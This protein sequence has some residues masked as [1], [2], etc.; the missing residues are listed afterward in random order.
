MEALR[1]GLEIP[2]PGQNVYVRGLSG[3]GRL[4]LVRRVLQEVR[5]GLRPGPDYAYVRRMSQPDRPRLL[6]LPRGRGDDFRERM[7]DVRQFVADELPR[8]LESDG[9][10]VERARL[11]KEAS[12]ALSAITDPLEK[13]LAEVGLALVL[14]TSR[15]GS[16][17]MVVP[18]VEGKPANAEAIAAA[19]ERGD[20]DDAELK[21]REQ[22][23]QHKAPRLESA[24]EQMAAVRT[25]ATDSMRKLA[26]REAA[27][28]IEGH[29]SD[30]RRDFPGDDV[31]AFLDD[32]IEDVTR[33]R[34]GDLG[35]PE[36][37]QRLY[38]VNVVVC[39]GPD[40]SWPVIVEN[41]P[42]VQTLVGVVD[43]SIDPDGGPRADHMSVRIGSL[44]LADGGVLVLEA[45]ELVSQP[46]AWSALV[47]T[48]R[49]GT[50][51]LVPPESP[52]P[53]R[54]ALLKP[55]PIEV[56]LK[57]VLLGEPGMYYLLD[58][59]D[60]DFPNLFKVLADFDHTLSRDPGGLELYAT[61]ISRLVAEESLPHFEATAVAEL[62]EH[63]ARIAAERDRLTARFGRLA[64]LAREAAYLARKDARDLVVGADVREAVG[65]TKRRAEG[66]ARRVRERIASGDV[67]IA[68]AGER[69]GQVNGLAVLSAGP[70]TYGV[71]TRITSTVAPGMGGTINIERESQLSGAIHTKAFYILGGL[72]RRL[73]AVEFPLTFEASIA[74]EQ[75][76]GGI[77]GDSASGA[78]I[79]CLLS[80]LTELPLRQSLAMTGAIDQVGNILM[81]GAVN[82]KI[83]GYFDTCRARGEVDGQGVLIPRANVPQLMLRHDVVEACANGRFSIYEV[84]RIQ[85]AIELLF[86]VPAPTV[87]ARAVERARLLWE[88][89]NPAPARPRGATAEADSAAEAAAKAD[90]EADG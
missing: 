25:E 54:A 83:E 20:I 37:L 14:A 66:P 13:E 44:A 6:T 79:C 76:Y 39:H 22:A 7:A 43:A 86:G 82:E 74:F 49:T 47:R 87:I 50:V 45:R 15:G 65:R 48:L 88:R 2:A 12:E 58:A 1:F 26:Q 16:R 89:S 70:L 77:D 32:L 42:S 9:L 19:K 36:T 71:P 67:R 85:D 21:K 17:P 61:V 29:V 10:R 51:D 53:W 33:R 41:A 34:L 46:G 90:A 59:A 63:G 69:V 3:T 78:E 31:A 8:A 55:D 57:V 4:T 80:A 24:L 60:A 73:L 38:D 28:A 35:D 56:K 27:T 30:L 52:R 23:A 81:I 40:E 72:M 11:E 68:V 84:D 62:A 75:S 18:L 5:P 64:D